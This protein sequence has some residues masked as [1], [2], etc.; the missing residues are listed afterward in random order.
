LDI[1]AD[2]ERAI[3]LTYLTALEA[4]F[5]PLVQAIAEDQLPAQEIYRDIAIHE[6]PQMEAIS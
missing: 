2:G 5:E 1:S 6:L 4:L 3:I